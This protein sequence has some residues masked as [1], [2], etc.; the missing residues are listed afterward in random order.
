MSETENPTDDVPHRSVDLE[1]AGDMLRQ[2]KNIDITT[3]PRE[4]IA[5]LLTNTVALIDAMGYEIDRGRH[6]ERKWRKLRVENQRYLKMLALTAG[7]MSSLVLRRETEQDEEDSAQSTLSSL[8]RNAHLVKL[9]IGEI[10]ERVKQSREKEATD[11][12]AAAA[13]PPAS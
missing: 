5:V 2:L 7:A 1:Q 6:Y 13:P 12:G 4:E 11:G 3:K 10:M 9:D 8:M